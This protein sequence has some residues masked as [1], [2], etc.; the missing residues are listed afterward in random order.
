MLETIDYVGPF[1]H[2][3]VAPVS[4]EHPLDCAWKVI[5][6]SAWGLKKQRQIKLDAGWETPL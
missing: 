3:F 4:G 6:K 2:D 1:G 5:E